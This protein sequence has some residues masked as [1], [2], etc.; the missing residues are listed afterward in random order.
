MITISLCMIV[1]NEEK[2]LE[3][4][5]SSIMEVMDE[6]IIVD[7]GST[8]QT[9]KIAG[10][11]TSNIFDFQWEDDF[12]KARNFAFS[13]ATMDYQMWLDADDILP[14]EEA[15]KLLE[16][17]ENLSPKTD[18]VTMKYHV[19]FDEF[20]QPL[21]TSTRERLVR[22]EAG[23]VWNDPVHE[24]IAMRGILLHS[25]IAIWHKKEA[26][27][28]DRNIKIYES[29]I[30][31]NEKFSPRSTYYFAR[32]LMD[33]KRYDEAVTYFE[34]FLDEKG[35]WIEDN[36]A[37]CLA[38][39]RCYSELQDQG[40][41]LLSLFRSFSYDLPRPDVCCEIA[42]YYK[43]SGDFRRGVYWFETALNAPKVDHSGFIY[44]DYLGYIPC[45]ELCVCFAQ[46]GDVENAM[47][48][49]EMAEKYKPDSEAVKY[50][51]KY[52]DSLKKVK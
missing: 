48:Y 33:H 3:R 41:R 37:A 38:L 1:K 51:K 29:R 18:V 9:K 31:R 40:K 10:K 2:V 50:N 35:G 45:I 43:H 15:K 11:Y 12:S 24:Y 22:R 26:H 52:F 8:D 46:M 42:Y 6:I 17:K 19:S 21:M 49:N 36:I 27:Y 5:L 30:E 39:G 7:T 32:E 44:N 25:D 14:P 4:C 34:K 28:S 20:D 23:F 16:L 13:K 47:K